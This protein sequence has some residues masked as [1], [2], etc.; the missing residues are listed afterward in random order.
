MKPKE[1]FKP[2]ELN[3]DHHT[4]FQTSELILGSI[5]YNGEIMVCIARFSNEAD[6]EANWRD[7]NSYLAANYISKLDSE[8]SRWNFYVFYLSDGPVKRSL[9]YEIE[10]NKF[11]SRKIID[12]KKYDGPIEKLIEAVIAEHITNDN[13]AIKPERPVKQDFKRNPLFSVISPDKDYLKGKTLEKNSEITT[14]LE[15]IE[16]L[17]KP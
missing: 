4:L 12:E 8:F 10:N 13:I 9:K 15:K 14:L 7:L 11:A 5:N 1:S 6:L 3:V 17:L 2:I 16:K